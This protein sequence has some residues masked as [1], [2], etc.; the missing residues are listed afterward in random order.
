[1]T[2]NGSD[3][4]EHL[5]LFESVRLFVDRAQAAKP[6]FRIT[7]SNAPAIAE[8]CDR[9][10]GMPLAIELAAAR[11]LVLTPSQMLVQLGNRFE[12]LVSRK[13]GI[14]ERQRTLRA[15]VDW[16]YRL[17]S[18]DMQRFFAQLYVFR[19][20]WT[21][22]AAEAVCEEPLALD[23]L[24]QLRECSLVST[25]EGESGIRFRMLESLREYAE[26]QLSVEERASLRGRHADFFVAEAEEAETRLK[27]PE[28]ALRLNRLQTE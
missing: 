22:E 4:P 7:N 9:L 18:P 26:V 16:S 2:P 14:A 12:F 27:G 6:D 1:P 5:S 11:A 8:L 28:Q 24:A 10:E 15:A 19:G 23:M 13:R 3:T 25:Q 20:G 21:L 17:L